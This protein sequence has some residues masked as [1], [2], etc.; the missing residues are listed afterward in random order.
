MLVSSRKNQ[1]APRRNERFGLKRFGNHDTVRN[2]L[3]DPICPTAH[4]DG[5]PNSLLHLPE[6]PAGDRTTARPELLLR[7]TPAPAVKFWIDVLQISQ[8]VFGFVDFDARENR[9]V[10]TVCSPVRRLPPPPP[11]GQRFVT[12]EAMIVYS[13]SGSSLSGVS[14]VASVNPARRANDIRMKEH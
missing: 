5:R 8:G 4:Q 11:H 3:R 6:W 2:N 7:G 10:T 1:P 13:C 14:H 12:H 9:S